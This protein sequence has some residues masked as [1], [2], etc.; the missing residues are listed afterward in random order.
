MKDKYL[1]DDTIVAIA[2]PPGEGGIG[3]IRVSGPQALGAL[4]K[5]WKGRK[6]VRAFESH[7]LYFGEFL[8][9]TGRKKIDHGLAVWM[10][11]PQSYTGEDVVEIHGHGGPLIMNLLQETLVQWGLR[12]AEPGEFTRRAFLNGKMDLLQAEAVGEMIHAQSEGALHNARSQLAGRLS[13]E[14]AE[15]RNRLI[16]LL[17]RLEAAIDFPEEDIEII[18]PLQSLQEIKAIQATLKNWEEKFHLGRLLREGVKVALVGR[19][20]VGKSSLLNRFMGEERAIVHPLPGTTRDVLEA[21]VHWEGIAIQLYDTAGIRQGSE[22]VER[23][24]I[25]RSRKIQAQA[26]LT[27]WLLDVSQNLGEEDRQIAHQLSGTTLVVGNKADLRVTSQTFPRE[28]NLPE[29][30]AQGEWTLISAKTGE[31]VEKLKDRVLRRLGLVQWNHQGQAYLNNSRHRES[32]RQAGAALNRAQNALEDKMPAECVAADLRNGMG[33]L[34][35]LLGEV[36]NE[37]VLDKIFQEF[38]LGK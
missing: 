20:N 14:I 23:V 33:A 22:E 34:A 24:G 1:K 18:Q 38:C 31:G 29:S 17:A 7:R 25:E 10:K 8:D 16:E 21:W 26:D 4:Q 32:L 3:I 36:S 13:L 2:T 27:L 15:I 35:A 9:L 30:L 5:I 6:S 28:W 12:V 11:G 37:E 19:P